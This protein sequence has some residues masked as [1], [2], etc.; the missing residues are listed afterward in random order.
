MLDRLIG[1]STARYLNVRLCMDTLL[2]WKMDCLSG[3]DVRESCRL[4]G[5]DTFIQVL[6]DTLRRGM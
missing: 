3:L 6:N 4:K 1:E 2:P 5:T